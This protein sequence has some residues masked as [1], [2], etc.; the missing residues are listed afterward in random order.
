MMFVWTKKDSDLNF[1][2]S[3]CWNFEC[4]LFMAEL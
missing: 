3:I 4:S 2:A 1:W